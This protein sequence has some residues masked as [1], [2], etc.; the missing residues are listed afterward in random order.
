MSLASL[1]PEN[2][3]VSG[4]RILDCAAGSFVQIAKQLG[5]SISAGGLSESLN[6]KRA[7][8]NSIAERLLET[9]ERMHD[10]QQAIDAPVNWMKTEQVVLALTIRRVA[11]VAGESE[12]HSFGAVA[13]TATKSVVQ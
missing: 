7:L 8:D 5:A 11:R 4:L 2:R 1:S 3:I 6:G 13:D 10:L 12:D 9:L